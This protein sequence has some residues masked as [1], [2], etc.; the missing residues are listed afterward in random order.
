MSKVKKVNYKL[1]LADYKDMLSLA[2]KAVKE[3]LIEK[4]KKK[5][6]QLENPPERKQRE[7]YQ[8]QCNECDH[9]FKR[10][11]LICPTCES[12]EIK[13]ITDYMEAS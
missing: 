3:L 1:I 7:K 11:P 13:R 9:K 12:E 6:D 8:F 2:K 4:L 10:A 5:I